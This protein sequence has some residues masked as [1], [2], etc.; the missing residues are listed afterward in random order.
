MWQMICELPEYERA[1]SRLH[2]KGMLRKVG[3]LL[4]VYVETVEV[5]L[6]L[7]EHFVW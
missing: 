1:W 5:P 2:M 4:A 6:N 3:L 7:G